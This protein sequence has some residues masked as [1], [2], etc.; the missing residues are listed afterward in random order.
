LLIA[1][2]LLYA[3]A[4]A[5]P[6]VQDLPAWAQERR[7]PARK[8]LV[9]GIGEYD[10][11]TQLSTPV[12]D[13]ALVAA[14]VRSLDFELPEDRILRGRVN[15]DTLL[16]AIKSFA[17]Q[18]G[19]GDLPFVYFSGH[20]I[21]RDGINY[22]VPSNGVAVTDE[23]GHAYVT[24]D[25]LL[26]KLD[27][28]GVATAIII[29]DA[30]RTDPFVGV[31]PE[32]RDL[33]NLATTTPA[34]QAEPPAPAPAADSA[35]ATAAPRP[36]QPSPPVASAPAGLAPVRQGPMAVLVAYAAQ[37][38]QAAFSLWLGEEPKVGSIYTRTLTRRLDQLRQFPIKEIL[39]VAEADVFSTTFQ[40]Q[41]PFQ[42]PFAFGALP[43]SASPLW[44]AL[45]E[46]TWAL[47]VADASPAQQ[48]DLLRT[49]I[50]LFP[51]SDFA[52]AARRRLAELSAAPSSTVML[53]EAPPD[54]ESPETSLALVGRLQSVA[55]A[56]GGAAMAGANVDL[57]LV[58]GWNSLIRDRIGTV[59]AG[60]QVRIVRIHPSGNAVRVV[61]ESGQVGYVGNI[62]FL[63]ADRLKEKATLSFNGSGAFA[64][65]AD[66][67]ALTALRPLLVRSSAAVTIRTAPP[68][69][70]DA[71]ADQVAHLRAL[72]IR[73]AVIAQG[74]DPRR[75]TLSPGDR[76]LPRDTAEVSVFRGGR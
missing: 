34:A 53:A 16:T 52:F 43:L 27:E 55:S 48:I 19:E 9:I 74:A 76:D 65:V 14:T 6:Q 54:T 67:S 35:P 21:E 51:A 31:E 5:A 33:L 56:E 42:H 26:D 29:L 68:G 11:A 70:S 10:Q 63:T 66:W 40:R 32:S 39:S 72:R 12:H 24:L 18:L 23:P 3:P 30:C 22:L 41:K 37:P 13:A 64:T 2:G 57:P 61:T 15:R 44:K 60:E 8:A 75:I 7:A 58:S 1:S 36:S 38:K 17:R 59:R 71:A 28:A 50:H 62:D 45:E 25:Y 4:L 73:E 46:E 47:S 20:G 49:F 69:T